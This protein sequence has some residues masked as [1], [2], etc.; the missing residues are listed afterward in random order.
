MSR[1]RGIGVRCVSAARGSP[2]RTVVSFR[3]GRSPGWPA[4]IAALS[5][6]LG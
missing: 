4:V 1:T 2:L 6:W 5:W 3:R